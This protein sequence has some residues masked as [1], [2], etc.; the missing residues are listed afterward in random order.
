MKDLAYELVNYADRVKF[1][2]L[3]EDVIYA[4]KKFVLDTLATTMAGSTAPGCKGI[5]GYIKDC[6][7]KQESTILV[8]GV[9]AI[10]SDVAFANST[11]N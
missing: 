6:G 7:G 1:D 2:D 3:P 10:A 9:K 8:Y 5:V 11:M 4:T